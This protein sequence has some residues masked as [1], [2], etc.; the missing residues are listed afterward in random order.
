M[1]KVALP[2]LGVLLFLLFML[3]FNFYVSTKAVATDENIVEIRIFDGN[4]GKE[5]II[6]DEA[7]IEEIVAMFN[8]IE[9]KKTGVSIGYVGYSYN[10]TY[11]NAQGENVQNFIVNNEKKLRYEGFFY[12]PQNKDMDFAMLEDV[13]TNEVKWGEH[14]EAMASYSMFISRL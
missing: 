4:T 1:K 8:A 11:Y 6:E 14:Y 3:T 9:F 7:I 5:A 12:E 2:V 10:V 13:M